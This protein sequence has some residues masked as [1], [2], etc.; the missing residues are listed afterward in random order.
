MEQTLDPPTARFGYAIKNPN[1]LPLEPVIVQ[2][3]KSRCMA[4]HDNE[5]KW[6]SF[7]SG[8]ELIGKIAV[9]G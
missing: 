5:G 7:Y 6:W 3:E 9:I 4:Y 8:K 2:T 1:P